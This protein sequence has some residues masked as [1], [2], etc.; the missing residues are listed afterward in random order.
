M[1]LIWRMRKSARHL[2]VVLLA[3]SITA[4]DKP[5][6]TVMFLLGKVSE[7]FHVIVSTT[8]SVIRACRFGKRTMVHTR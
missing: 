4:I 5:V 1:D 8:I 2:Y 7:S 3:V 6:V